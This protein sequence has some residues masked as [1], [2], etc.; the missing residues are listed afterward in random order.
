MV[1][2]RGFVPLTPS[3]SLQVTSTSYEVF[4]SRPTML[5]RASLT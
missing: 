3:G 1:P 4:G 5:P 2:V